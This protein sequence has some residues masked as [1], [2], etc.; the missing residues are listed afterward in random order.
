M[1]YGKEEQKK[2]IKARAEL[3]R[4]VA[5]YYRDIVKVYK[6]FDGKVYNC[7]LEKAL[8]EATDNKVM[9]HNYANSIEVHH[10]ERGETFILTWIKK[11]DLKDGKR[12]DAE[13]WIKSA[14]ERREK[15]L[16]EAY[17][18]EKAADDLD[19]I[20]SQLKQLK[21]TYNAIA[22]GLPYYVRSACNI[23]HLY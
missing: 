13:F 6:Q 7:R 4:T 18:L 3:L 8:R 15:N 2:A 9:I 22:D 21:S 11:E 17:E 16:T 5:G 23:N 12:I 14:R 10:Y 20:I 19:N 1:F